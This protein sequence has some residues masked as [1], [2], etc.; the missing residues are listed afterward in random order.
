MYFREQIPLEEIEA[1]TLQCKKH[2]ARLEVLR[3][4]RATIEEQISAAA[5]REIDIDVTTGAHELFVDNVSKGTDTAGAISVGMFYYGSTNAT[6]DF[7]EGQLISVEW[8]NSVLTTFLNHDATASSHATGTPILSDISGS[9]LDVTGANMPTDGSAWIDLGGG[10]TATVNETGPSFTESINTNLSVNITGNIAESGPSFTESV[11]AT[12]SALTIQ[13][14]ITESGPSFNESI[15]AN[16][17]TSLTINASIAETG[18]SFTE[19]ISANLDTNLS[20]TINELGPSF[21]ESINVSTTTKI[22]ATIT[23]FGPSFSE[24]IAA[25]IP[26]KVSLNPRNSV[27]VKRKSNAVKIK[28]KSNNIRVK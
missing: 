20:A 2:T 25:S 9:G 3:E 7:F 1:K 11:S 8:T 6:R 17:T 4:E 28:R 10:I 15:S 26:I 12:L 13:A 21:T 19:S 23:E 14:V 22:S 24:N 18:P 5:E 16:V 27:K